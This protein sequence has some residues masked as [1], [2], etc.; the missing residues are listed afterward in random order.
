[1]KAKLILS[2]SISI[3][4][5][6]CSAVGWHLHSVYVFARTAPASMRQ[7]GQTSLGQCP[8]STILFALFVQYC[9]SIYMAR[10]ACFPRNSKSQ[11]PG[12]AP[13][14]FII[15]GGEMDR[16]ANWW[17]GGA[18]HCTALL[19]ASAENTYQDEMR[20]SHLRALSHS[21]LTATHSEQQWLIIMVITGRWYIDPT[22]TS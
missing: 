1:M 15:S 7:F 16:I 6:C 20:D 8:V 5:T 10:V 19:A 17:P 22:R 4:S 13:I 3:Q 9:S 11:S 21:A 2:N 18:L 14:A 12:N